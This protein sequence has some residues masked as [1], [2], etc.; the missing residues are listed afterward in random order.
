[1]QNLSFANI[2]HFRHRHFP[3]CHHDF[4]GKRRDEFLDI[5]STDMALEASH[6]AFGTKYAAIHKHPAWDADM[7][8]SEESTSKAVAKPPGW[9]GKKK[10]TAKVMPKHFYID[11]F[12]RSDYDR[13]RLGRPAT[14]P[15]PQQQRHSEPRVT[16]AT[17]VRH[18][19]AFG[20][21]KLV[22]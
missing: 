8:C 17:Y 18:W 4:N 7:D 9:R 15:Q 5:V 22:C 1:M 6:A 19:E 10:A 14:Q 13:G 16:L 12:H 2:H 3:E 20:I 21:S 11:D